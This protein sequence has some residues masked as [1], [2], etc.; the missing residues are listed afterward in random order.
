MSGRGFQVAETVTLKNSSGTVVDTTHTI[1]DGSFEF[2]G[3]PNDTYTVTSKFAK[4]T[5]AEAAE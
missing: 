5:C 1:Q 3:V 4:V 2:T